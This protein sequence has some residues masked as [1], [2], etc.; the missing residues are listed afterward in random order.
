M[1]PSTP[2]Y[3]ATRSAASW[4]ATPERGKLEL[5]G[6]DAPQFLHNLSTN[7]ITGLPVGGGCLAFLATST[8][9]AIAVVRIYHVQLA[10]QHALWLD[11]P[12][13]LN[14]KVLRHLDR[15]LIA[16]QVEIV[17]HTAQLAQWHLAGP[18]A[19]DVLG[20]M[21][22]QTVPAL[23]EHQHMARQIAGV[24]VQ[25]R[26]HDPLGVPG[27][28]LVAPRTAAAAVEAAFGPAGASAATADDYETLRLEAGTPA[29]GIDITDERF[30]VEVNLPSAISYNKGCYLGQE[31]IVMS[32]DRAGH[33][34]RLFVGIH[35]A[36]NHAPLAGS[37]IWVE[38]AEVGVVTSAGWSPRLQ[39]PLALGYVRWKHH[40]VGTAV[41]IDDQAGTIVALPLGGQP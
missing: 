15:H 13:G 9:K 20:R 40:A 27:F 4:L 1:L 16:E 30:V 18:N 21:L 3:T 2:G 28:D 39:A 22:G 41:R 38:G 25:I 35:L 8:A 12:P 31:P 17:D 36:G 5:T 29:Y 34:P 37:K 19:A 7:H 6:P 10:G 24:A 11:T 32:R 26:R 23:A 14:E 33:A